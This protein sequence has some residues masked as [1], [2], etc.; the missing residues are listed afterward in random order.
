[1][2]VERIRPPKSLVFGRHLA[3]SIDDD[4]VQ[5]A[6][7]LHRGSRATLLNVNK[8]Y[9]SR[10]LQTDAERSQFIQQTIAEYVA[11][12]GGHKREIS[13]TVAGPD[14][15][16]RTARVPDTRSRLLRAASVYEAKKQLPFPIT[17]CWLD[18][19]P[20]GRITTSEG[21]QKKV[22]ILA[23]TRR[24][25][26]EKLAP[27]HELGL[28]VTNV[29][30]A[31]DVL[32]QLL[33]GLPGFDQGSSYALINVQGHRTEIAYYH[34]TD[35]VF[36][37]VTSIGSSFLANRTDPTVYEYF[38][39]SLATEIQNSL[40]YYSGQYSAHF[41]NRVFV[42]GDLAYSDDLINL[43]SDRFG[44]TFCR[45][46]AETLTT[47]RMK[48]DA[49][50]GSLSVCLPVVAASSNQT[51]LANLLPEPQ[52][53][54][55]RQQRI[56]RYGTAALIVLALAGLGYWLGS[57]TELRTAQAGLHDLQRQV[58]EFKSREV[59]AT[60]TLLKTKIA[61]DQAFVAKAQENPSYL[62]L[63]LKELSRIT[64]ADVRLISIAYGL[65][66][67][68]QDLQVSGV[69][70]T[71]KSPP[72]IV[73]AEFVENMKASPFYTDV[74]IQKHIKRVTDAGF[75]MDFHLSM[76]AVI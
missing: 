20:V 55:R 2:Q 31:Q 68:E 57:L 49:D 62:G 23:A 4:S 73:L 9:I 32:G 76:R 5:M 21:K 58:E 52:K 53:H 66:H 29:Y 37:H 47:L 34:G 65:A 75:E 38:A 67:G 60:Y 6:A 7:S 44:F 42:Y 15:V 50:E 12:Y 46:P 28:S 72:E 16:F 14:T 71:R 69:V 11:T 36:L 64:P 41:S 70:T 30:H 54:A 59:F 33:R 39:E 43:L 35:L 48:H 19:R 56:N 22:A 8:T 51:A 25:I 40:D 10:T 61:R 3:F 24:L 13:V 27:F 26:N 63:N 74:T 18:F 1:M 17:D 45:F